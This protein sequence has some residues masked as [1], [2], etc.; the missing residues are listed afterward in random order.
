M[1]TRRI[2]PCLDIKDGRTVK[3]IEFENLRDVGDPVELAVRYCEE[4]ADELVFLDITAS[5]EKR[6]TIFD[7]VEQVGEAIQ[8]PFTV[9]GG[10]SNLDD[11]EHLLNAGADKVSLNSAIIERP[12]LLD[13]AARYI[14]SQSVVAA[15]DA[16]REGDGW[17]VWTKG[18][19]E[20]TDLNALLWAGEVVQRGAGELLITSMDKDGGNSGYDLELLY[21]ISQLVHV[22]VIASGGA[23]KHQHFRD[24]LIHGRADAVL[25]A[26]VFHY[27][28]MSIKDLKMYLHDNGI[29]VRL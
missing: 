9:G 20:R 1:L 15:I 10:V 24:A 27:K 19:S 4:G 13:E 23:G 26:S 28:L 29:P 7:L 2:I 6:K 3:G 14:G 25:A 11:V 16:K 21:T 5:K 22:P 12:A 8:I 17:M 18:G